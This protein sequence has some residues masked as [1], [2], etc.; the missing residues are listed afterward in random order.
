[1]SNRLDINPYNIT[2]QETLIKDEIKRIVF[3]HE[4]TA[5]NWTHIDNK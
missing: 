4:N 1:M 2:V 5:S 3:S